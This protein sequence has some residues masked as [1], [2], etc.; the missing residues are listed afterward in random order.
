MQV[1][2][3]Y[4]LD[5][6]DFHLALILFLCLFVVLLYVPSQHLWRSEQPRPIPRNSV[7]SDHGC[8][9]RIYFNNASNNVTLTLY[10]VKLTSQKPC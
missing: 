3:L 9:L 5:L 2:D 1:S 6:Y 8:T 4:V 10:N 7:E